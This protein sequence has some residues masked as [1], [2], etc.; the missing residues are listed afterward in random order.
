MP[1]GPGKRQV[2]ITLPEEKLRDF[3]V[4]A[5]KADMT[6]SQFLSSAGSIIEPEQITKNVDN[7]GVV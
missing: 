4:K 1:I 5:A 7:R 2:M 3:K 6:L